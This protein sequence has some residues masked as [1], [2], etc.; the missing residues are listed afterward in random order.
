MDECLFFAAFYDEE[1][2]L[3]SCTSQTVSPLSGSSVFRFTE[4]RTDG[5]AD[6]EIM[7]K[8]F[9]LSNA[10]TPLALSTSDHVERD[11]SL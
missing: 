5:I 11:D 3:L 2:Q 10:L 7:V 1:D 9:L 4:V 6:K 8:V